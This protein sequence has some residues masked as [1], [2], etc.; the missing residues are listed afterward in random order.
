MRYS[1]S[2]KIRTVCEQHKIITVIFI[3]QV[4]RALNLYQKYR[5]LLLGEAKATDLNTP[6]FVQF[7]KKAADAGTLGNV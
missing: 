2:V 4:V 1:N 5:I 3:Y 6:L 7:S